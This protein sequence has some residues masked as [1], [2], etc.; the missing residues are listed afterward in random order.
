MLDG[1]SYRGSFIRVE[2]RADSTSLLLR[3]GLTISGLAPDTVSFNVAAVDSVSE[4]GR[5]GLLQPIPVVAEIA[6][7]GALL[8]ALIASQINLSGLN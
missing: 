8:F 6:I 5:H 3:Q 2:Q 7:L 4:V 1:S